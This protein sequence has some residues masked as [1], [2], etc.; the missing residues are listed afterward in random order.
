MSR[1]TMDE[2]QFEVL[3]KCKS[4]I[5]A[6]SDKLGDL[7]C[8][9]IPPDEYRSSQDN[10]VEKLKADNSDSPKLPPLSDVE[11][12]VKS[13]WKD[14]NIDDLL[15]GA[16][17]AYSFMVRYF[18]DNKEEKLK[19][20]TLEKRAFVELAKPVREGNH[21]WARGILYAV[22]RIRKASNA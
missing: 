19:A 9:L 18:T 7:T 10:K 1:Y 12:H 3:V 17:I 13:L 14:T 15:T 4:V 6:A 22:N 16:Q 8:E 20:D 2:K 11:N 5:Q 21:Q